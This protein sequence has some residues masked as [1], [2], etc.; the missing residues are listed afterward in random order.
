MF[1]VKNALYDS[2]LL[3]T[4]E[5]NTV[6]PF[7]YSINPGVSYGLKNKQI[8]YPQK[9]GVSTSVYGQKLV[10]KVPKNGYLAQCFVEC[11][12]TC[13]GDNSGA[14]DRI[15]ARV[16]SNISFQTVQGSKDLQRLQPLYTNSRIDQLDANLSSHIESSVEPDSSFNNNTVVC[17]APC[18]FWFSER[19]Q[20]FLNTDILEDFQVECVVSDTKELIGLEEDLT[21]VSFRLICT[22]YTLFDVYQVPKQLQM[23]SFDTYYET[24]IAVEAGATSLKVILDCNKT[25]YN[26]HMALVSA[27]Q[28]YH[29]IN[30]F[31]LK[32][33]NKTVTE[34]N[35]RTNYS[36]YSYEQTETLTGTF[37]YWFSLQK[38]RYT[39]TLSLPML[40][41]PSKELLIEF[42]EIPAGYTAYIFF[43]YWTIISIDSNGSL[44]KPTVF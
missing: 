13:T 10:F 21:A 25:V 3:N 18:F 20:N 27:N 2:P 7:N 29:R 28:E 1:Q 44:D 9:G 33:E 36:L 23:L 6:N 15:G 16:F 8:V 32:T 22:Y 12:L 5:N 40:K 39:N 38:V 37:S 17:Y 31:H 14:E 4:L 35:R 24:P 19:P 26:M 42:D 30:N 34:C 43:E 11:T 41:L